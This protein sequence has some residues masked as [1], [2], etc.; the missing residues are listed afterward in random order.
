MVRSLLECELSNERSFKVPPFGIKADIVSLDPGSLS[1]MSAMSLG[2]TLD[3]DSLHRLQCQ[4]DSSPPPPHTSS[5]SSSSVTT[6]KTI[7]TKL[8]RIVSPNSSSRNIN[9]NN[10]CKVGATSEPSDTSRSRR[11]TVVRFSANNNTMVLAPSQS[12]HHQ[13]HRKDVNLKLSTNG[14]N[15]KYNNPNM[16]G[17]TIWFSCSASLK[18]RGKIDESILAFPLNFLLR[19]KYVWDGISPASNPAIEPSTFSFSVWI[20]GQLTVNLKANKVDHF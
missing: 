17:R 20:L 2:L 18:T 15:M 16:Q 4:D 5:T 1:L 6:A 9:N 13:S 11:E 12:H 8:V 10:N 7:A 14:S 19:L 3:G